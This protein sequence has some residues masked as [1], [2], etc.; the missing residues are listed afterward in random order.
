M[1]VARTD[2]VAGDAGSRVAAVVARHERTLLRVARQASLCHDDA[3]DA[4]QRALEI[5]VRRVET[6]DPATEV[7]WLK[8]VVRH[9]AMAIRRARSESVDG[10]DVDVDAFVPGAER[11]V[12]EQIASGERVRRSAEALRALKPDEAKALMLKAH[13]LSYEEIGARNG[14]SYT[15]VNR[16]ITE[17]RRRFLQAYEEIESGEE[18]ERL[19][20]IVE[21]LSTGS[22]TSAQVVRIRPHLRHCSACRAAVRDLHLSRARRASLFWPVLGLLGRAGSPEERLDAI[23]ADTEAVDERIRELLADG[24]EFVPEVT[25]RGVEAPLGLVDQIEPAGRFATLKHDITAFFHR[26]QA[27]DVATGVHLAAAGGSGRIATLGAVIGLCL[28]GAGVGTVCVVTGVVSDPFGLIR[29][30]AEPPPRAEA[31]PRKPAPTSVPTATATPARVAATP[32]AT[33]APTPTPRPPR[34]PERRRR[35]S[36][37]S[38][39]EDPA[40]GTTPTSHQNA[41]ISPAQSSTT[42]QESFTPEISQSPAEPAAAPAT[43][44]GEFA[45]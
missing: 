24:G 41:P 29:P 25:G 22:A 3:L 40:Q 1:A 11:S 14:W 42:G 4:Y 7:A 8:V 28:S 31:K 36:A 43:G 27:S 9:E 33:P 21:A 6:V 38:A 32:T 20:P 34:R 16:A 18:C 45:P 5:F 2:G 10:E 15:K 23:A 17:G 30:E 19:A 35:R 44:G 12:E 39:A 37:P 26:A 13:G